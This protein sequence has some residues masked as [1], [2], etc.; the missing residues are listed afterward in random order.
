MQQ[1]WVRQVQ[2]V[3]EGSQVPQVHVAVQHLVER[4]RLLARR[5]PGV[6]QQLVE[7]VRLVVQQRRR[8]VGAAVV[9]RSAKLALR[10]RWL[11]GVLQGANV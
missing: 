10:V 7:Q 6:V 1:K 4:V 3:P 11:L 9:A 8:V 5:R 2:V